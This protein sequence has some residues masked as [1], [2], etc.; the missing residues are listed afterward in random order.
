MSGKFTVSVRAPY[1]SGWRKTHHASLAI[2][3]GGAWRKHN[4]NFSVDSITQEQRVIINSEELAQ[5]FAQM[6]NLAH[7][8]PK[9]PLHE[10]AEQVIQEI[11]KAEADKESQES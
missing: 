1:T 6:D 9:R 2:A 7:D 8:Q 11:D 10:I 5:A 3:L 4:N